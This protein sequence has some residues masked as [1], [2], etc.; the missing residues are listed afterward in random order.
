MTGYSLEQLRSD[1]DDCLMVLLEGMPL[2]VDD[3]EFG[4]ER[5]RDLIERWI[6]RLD[7]RVR[8]IPA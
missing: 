6:E 4:D 1:Y 3:L 2:G 8:H 5:G 7:A